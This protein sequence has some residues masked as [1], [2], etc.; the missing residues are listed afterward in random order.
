MSYDHNVY[1]GWYAEFDEHHEKIESGVTKT[2]QCPNNKKHFANDKFCPS[3]GV[4][5]ITIEKS[6]YKSFVSALNLYRMIDDYDTTDE[7]VKEATLGHSTLDELKAA[8]KN[9]YMVFPEFL[10]THKKILMAP[11]YT[12]VSDITRSDGSVKEITNVAAP[13]PEWKELVA[14]VFKA[15]NLEFKYGVVVEVM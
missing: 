1:V 12:R 5:I 7:D 6:T 2:R 8:A 4:E 10:T 11:G 9:A 3:C 15:K 13:S 14:K